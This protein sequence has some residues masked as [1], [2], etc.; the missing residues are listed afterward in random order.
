MSR[1]GGTTI[2]IYHVLRL[3]AV[4]G[5]VGLATA[6]LVLSKGV[7][8]TSHHARFWNWSLL[9]AYVR[10]PTYADCQKSSP[11]MQLYAFALVLA[12][13]L[14][15]SKTASVAI[16]HLVWVLLGIWAVYGYRDI[17]PLGTFDLQPLDFHEGWLM[18]AKLAVLTFAAAIVPAFIPTQ[19]IPFDPKVR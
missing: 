17:Y 14:A 4:L 3:L 18:W 16:T 10:V 1:H 7:A 9:G 19:Y 6:T 2:F 15:P 12:A 5:L 8:H 11:S 13:V